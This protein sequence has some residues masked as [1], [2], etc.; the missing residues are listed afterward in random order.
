MSASARQRRQARP[1]AP[2][3][4]H[5]VTLLRDARRRSAAHLALAQHQHAHFSAARAGAWA[6]Q[7]ASALT[8]GVGKKAAVQRQ[9]GPQRGLGHGRVHGRV[10]HARDGHTWGQRGVGQQAV[11]TRP[12]ALDQAQRGRPC[13]QPGGG[14]ATTRGLHVAGR[15][16]PR[17]GPAKRFGH[18]RLQGCIQACARRRPARHTA[19]P[20]SG[21]AA[22]VSRCSAACTVARARHR[23]HLPACRHSARTAC[24]VPQA[25]HTVP[26][27][28]PGH[29][30][31]G[32]GNA[33][34][35]H[36]QLHRRALQ[37]AGHHGTR[38]GLADGTVRLDQRVGH[39]PSN[40]VLARL[41]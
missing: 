29:R 2:P 7:R 31:A 10:H 14:L 19:A 25:S 24:A 34:H 27:G 17:P 38:H 16:V 35:G 11:H 13:R 20:S 26:T 15:R 4:H 41:L 33:G 32:A 22:C 28:L 30:A 21:L 12:Q 3:A 39:T 40:S 18:G 8:F 5:R 23:G 37:R 9:H 6:C 36:R 1:R